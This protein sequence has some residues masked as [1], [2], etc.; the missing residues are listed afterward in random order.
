MKVLSCEQT[1]LLE[2]TAVDNGKTYLELMRNAGSAAAEILMQNCKPSDKIA[3]ICGK[4]NNGG[5]GFVIAS[6]LYDNGYDVSVILADGMP[7]TEDALAMLEEAQKAGL[8]IV[9]LEQEITLSIINNADWVVDALYGIGFKGGLNEQYFCLLDCIKGRVLSVDLPSGVQCDTG[10]V[11]T[12]AFKADITVSFSTL[13]PANVLQPG[14]EYCGEVYVANVGI[15][16]KLISLSPYI[17]RTIE[18]DIFKDKFYRDKN[19]N[20][21]TFGNAVCVCGSY[22]MAGAAILCGSAALRSGAG[23]VKMCVPNSIYPIVA[24][25][26]TEAIFVPYNSRSE[27]LSAC[28]KASCAAIG[29]GM[30]KSADT[31]AIV[32]DIITKTDLPVVLDADGINSV[33]EHIDILRRGNIIITPHPQEFARL[34]AVDKDEIQA[35]RIGYSTRFAKE[36]GVYV[37]LKGANTVIAAPD[38]EVFVN[39]TGNPGMARGGSGDVL[40]GIITALLAQGLTLRDAA[41][42][43]VYIHGYAGDIAC[44]ERG[45][46]SMLPT[47]ITEYLGK[48]FKELI[49]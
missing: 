20:K 12:R 11:Q 6:H 18:P 19:A 38:G 9:K 34:N 40:T 41:L 31:L 14:N 35:D 48:S 16:E 39:T 4:G 27:V 22:G 28:A 24:P 43:G 3:V 17:A 13:K 26:L 8:R 1:R 46:I 45:M 30:G 33:C 2:K 36:Y 49:G 25:S 47:D 15:S 23:L 37:V 32:E 21:G 44:A 5:D 10:A 42:C 29:C 7:K